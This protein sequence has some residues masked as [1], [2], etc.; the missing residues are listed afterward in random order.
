VWRYMCFAATLKIAMLKNSH[1]ATKQL[2]LR[3]RQ[4]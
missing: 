1:A 4:H 3:L 2:P